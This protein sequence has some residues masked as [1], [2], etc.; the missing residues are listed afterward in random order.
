MIETKK[1]KIT[2][3]L[4]FDG[5]VVEHEYPYIG[6]EN[7]NC[8]EILRRWV[9]EYNVGLILDT[10]RGDKELTEAIE[11]FKERNIHLYGV[12]E[13][14][15]QKNWTKSTKAYAHYSI[16]D[17]NVGCPL[18]NEFGKRGRVNWDKIVEIFEPVLKQYN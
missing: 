16:D 9:N 18:H 15:T 12:Q 7:D 11:W 6:K 14:P 1:P 17:R 8:S 4:D 5:T 13:H 3:A 2:I 10:M